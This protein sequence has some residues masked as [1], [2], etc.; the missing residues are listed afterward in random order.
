MFSRLYVH[1]VWRTRGNAALIDLQRAT[2]LERIL[3]VLARKERAVLL[4]VGMV[5]THVHTVL[6][7]HS[8]TA[9]ARLAQRL[10]GGSARMAGEL[11]GDGAERLAWA[12]GYSAHSV[13]EHGLEAALRYVRF[14]PQRHPGE[15]IPGYM[16]RG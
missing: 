14:Q 3:P 1:M 5:A 10:K 4:G 7:I 11:F 12:K 8:T 2:F 6:R 16:P 13:G 9:I 15:A